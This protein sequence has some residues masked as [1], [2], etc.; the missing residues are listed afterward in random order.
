MAKIGKKYLTYTG[1][2]ATTTELAYND[3]FIVDVDG[4]L[5]HTLRGDDTEVELPVKGGGIYP[6]DVAYMDIGG[7]TTI[8]QVW[9]VLGQDQ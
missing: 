9:L 1:A 7:S 8:S 3:G 5:H 4:I 2:L 6:C